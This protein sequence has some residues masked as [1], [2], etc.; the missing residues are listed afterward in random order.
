[1]ASRS[2]SATTRPLYRPRFLGITSKPL[3]RTS[4]SIRPWVSTTPMTA[5]TPSSRRCRP[6]GQHLERLADSR[7][8][9][10]KDAKL[11]TA[12]LIDLFQQGIG[13]RT[14]LGDSLSHPLR[15]AQ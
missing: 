1:M 15:L 2:I 4:V 13:R 5:S 10:Q 12:F 14:V 9:A 6:L 7:R 11:A 3:V 8:G